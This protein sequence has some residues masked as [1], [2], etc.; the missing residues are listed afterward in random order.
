MRKLDQMASV[1]GVSC[2]DSDAELAVI[3]IKY[4]GNVNIELLK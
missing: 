2:I 3:N 4:K 1:Y